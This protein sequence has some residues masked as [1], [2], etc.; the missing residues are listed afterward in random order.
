MLKNLKLSK[1]LGL[2]FGVVLFLMCVISAIS[3]TKLVSI[4]TLVK[5]RDAFNNIN[6][7]IEEA[8][9]NRLKL[10][11][12]GD[13]QYKMLVDEAFEKIKATAETGLKDF[14][15][16]AD[17]KNFKSILSDV[18]N[19][20]NNFNVFSSAVAQ[21]SESLAKLRESGTIV[22]ETADRIGDPNLAVNLISMRF[23][24]LNYITYGKQEFFDKQQQFYNNVKNAAAAAKDGNAD[25]MT[26][27]NALETYDVNFKNMAEN[28]RK[29]MDVE[30]LMTEAAQR[31]QE[32]CSK[33]ILA[34]KEAMD[35]AVKAAEFMIIAISVIAIV[36]GLTIGFFISKSITKPMSE[37]VKA[38]ETM[39]KGNFKHTLNIHQKD[40]VGQFAESL[41][42]MRQSLSNVIHGLVESSNAV[43]S[44][45]TELA[46]TTEELATTFSD[47]AMQVSMVAAAVEE[48]SASSSE[49]LTSVN[50]VRDKS[51]N[52]KRM[53]GE[54]QTYIVSA[55][56]VME[57]IQANVEEL[58]GTISSLARSSE[59]IGSI[60]LVINDIADQTNLLALNAAIEA[61][62]AGEH[63]RGFAVVADE[64]RKLAER[65]QKSIHEIETIIST[66]VRETNKTNDEMTTAKKRVQEGVSTLNEADVIFN[67]IVEAVDEI[68]M[69]SGIIN[70]AVTEQVTAINNIND[71]AHV[72][73]SGLEESSV[74]VN[75][76]SVTVADLQKQ[77]DSQMESARHFDI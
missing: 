41:E 76:V 65:T 35:S 9:A 33:I 50:D 42:K 72:I 58:G 25:F 59:E 21:K 17:Q 44:A 5:K 6:S 13:M 51:E 46:S 19:Y 55:N 61:A 40:E 63:G 49:V 70:A 69:A 1:K 56:R 64:V 16:D 45:S 2:G 36:F 27:Y 11:Y 74:A 57:S 48:I 37:A 26:I 8:R 47:Q 54:G 71:N 20:L 31:A 34:E 38:A 32:T 43:A 52:T 77:A 66:F 60:L 73:S 3:F 29:R 4:S 12:T 24:A 14:N 68:S 10:N 23:Y 62:R 53:T 7:E 30:K 75:E 15:S 28:E 22:F 39:A 67:R 18:D